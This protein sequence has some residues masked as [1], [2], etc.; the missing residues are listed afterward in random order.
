MEREEK[1]GEVSCYVV[2]SG[3]EFLPFFP[4]CCDNNSFSL[5][6]ISETRTPVMAE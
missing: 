6:F 2:L 1:R 3:I 5:A 4:I